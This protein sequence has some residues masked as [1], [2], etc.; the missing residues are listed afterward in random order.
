M[1]EGAKQYAAVLGG[2][3]LLIGLLL[4]LAVVP[5]RMKLGTAEAQLTRV[6]NEVVQRQQRL[7]PLG[8]LTER[9]SQLE[10]ELRTGRKTLPRQSELGNFL[11]RISRIVDNQRLT[12][13][14]ITPGRLVS[15]GNM[16]RMPMKMTFCGS[17]AGVFAFLREVEALPHYTRVDELK[18][19][20]D[21]RYKGRLTVSL[22]ISVFFSADGETKKP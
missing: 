6:E 9:V 18:L 12:D 20:N 10:T 19:E 17:M 1:T 8:R 22:G 11:G 2:G 3:A 15:Q 5:S 21:S 14:E 13:L 16:F 4:F 7:G